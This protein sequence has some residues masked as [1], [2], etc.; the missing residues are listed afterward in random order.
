MNYH[1]H[2]Y[3]VIGKAEVNLCDMKDDTEARQTALD[4]VKAETVEIKL[5]GDCR[6]IAIAFP[7]DE[8]K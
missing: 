6:F 3:Q 4:M 2:V 8:D 7:K 5:P 1:V